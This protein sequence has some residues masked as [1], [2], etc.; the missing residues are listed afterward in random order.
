MP[1]ERVSIRQA[2]EI[3]RLKYSTGMPTREGERGTGL[4]A[5]GGHERARA[6][7]GALR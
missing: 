1:A 6:E 3:I 4:A 2:R 7:V 5:A